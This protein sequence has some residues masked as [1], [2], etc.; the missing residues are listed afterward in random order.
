MTPGPVGI[1]SCDFEGGRVF[2]LTGE[3]DACSGRG[4][5]LELSG[6]PGSLI[7]ID[8]SQISFMDSSGI[9]II[10]AARQ[11][12]ISRSGNLV[13]T[14]PMPMIQKVLEITGLDAW[15]TDW[16]HDWPD[17]SAKEFSSYGQNL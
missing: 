6:P 14:R 11:E 5:T 2:T 8:L 7:V 10:N 4:L 1:T 16:D 13:V 3:L 15:I 12:A 9:A 17:A